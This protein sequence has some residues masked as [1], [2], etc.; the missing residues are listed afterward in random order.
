MHEG[1]RTGEDD[2]LDEIFWNGGHVHVPMHE[3][4]A[5]MRGTGGNHGID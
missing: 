5:V 2:L 1:S 4:A 3:N